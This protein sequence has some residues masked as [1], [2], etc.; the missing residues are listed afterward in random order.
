MES[1]AAATTSGG[2]EDAARRVLS[3]TGPLPSAGEK[4]EEED[5][6][7][8]TDRA[9]SEAATADGGA[10]PASAGNNPP[11]SLAA[12]S[13]AAVAA[14]TATVS[15]GVATTTSLSTPALLN[16]YQKVS[17]L[18]TGDDT[19]TYMD[20]QGRLKSVKVHEL[21]DIIQKATP[22]EQKK[23]K[24]D[25]PV[26]QINAVASYSR[27]VPANYVLPNSY[28]RFQKET[29]RIQEEGMA[30]RVDYVADAEDEQW[31]QGKADSWQGIPTSSSHEEGRGHDQHRPHLLG[32]GHH[33]HHLSASST[34]TLDMLEVMMDSLEK[35]TGFETIVTFAQAEALLLQKLPQLC[36][37]FPFKRPKQHQQQSS[38]TQHQQTSALATSSSSAAHAHTTVTVTL[39][40]VLSD[41]YQY[42]VQK[43]SK[44]KRPLL[45][46]FWP[47]T[48]TDDT[49]PHLVFRPR[50]KEKYKLRKKRQ[51][52]YDAY[53]KIK[54]LRSDFD[55]LRA[56]VELVVRREELS[57][58]HLRCH[59]Q[60]FRERLH[61]VTDTSLPATA[62]RRHHHL[63]LERDVVPPMLPR[64]LRELWPERRQV[65]VDDDGD[66]AVEALL[67]ANLEVPLHFDTTGGGRKA[68]R[69]RYDG[70]G[71]DL[72]SSTGGGSNT[73]LSLATPYAR[74]LDAPTA[75][76]GG[77]ACATAATATAAAGGG[78]PSSLAASAPEKGLNVAGRN[79]GEPAPLFLHP[80]S[81]RETLATTWEAAV[82]HLPSYRD[83]HP[84]PVPSFRHRPRVG[85]GG[86]ICIDRLPVD[87]SS[88][89]GYNYNNHV[90]YTAGP[91]LPM[92]QKA[93]LLDL[94]PRPI[95]YIQA[96]QR[97][98]ELVLRD[99][100][101][102]DEHEND[103]E[104]VVVNLDAWLGTDDPQ[105]GEE[106]FAIGP[107]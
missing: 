64:L 36:H 5:S 67:S 34:V 30:Q 92:P 19:L 33:H 3:S 26:P 9:R 50:E 96:S 84:V 76:D 91:P 94:L 41:V 39:K 83:S 52:D 7:R 8:V 100:V 51:N 27:D 21:G 25:I 68:K 81:T 102:G 106:R 29:A 71:S 59:V 44:L 13:A 75:G 87:Q 43:R 20:A 35:A 73:G 70:S 88:G 56:M 2:S 12:A 74:D 55:N 10:P 58:L 65:A 32:T 54:Q 89:G 78:D 15:S 69:V 86:R 38:T 62:R 53:L 99:D 60:V 66:D 90:Y 11:P 80:L 28:V 93:R 98:Q 79:Y 4:K 22:L 77:N 45:R 105:W 18:R 101:I 31:L 49:N 63:S 37:L 47:V 48:S 23:V 95:D 104:E 82:P 1:A 85:R 14:A 24:L 72:T 46:Q 42:W 40:Q 97:I 17:V 61:D 6:G 107:I 57:R 16:L 103:G